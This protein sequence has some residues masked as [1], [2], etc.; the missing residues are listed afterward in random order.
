[1]T[2]QAGIIGTGGVAGMG[3]LGMHDQ[4][5]IGKEPVDAS[6]AG[7]YARSDEIDLVAAAD[8]DS[9]KLETFGEVWEIAPDRRYDDHDAMLAAEDL[10]VVSVATP[11][12]LHH[13]HVV[14][15]AESGADP[16]VIWCEK[17]IASSVADAEAMVTAC[18][19]AGTELV[20]NHTT[21]FTENMHAVRTLVRD[22]LIG[23]IQAGSGTFRMELMRNSTHLIDTLVYLLDARA[24]RVSGYLTGENEAVDAL[25]ADTSVDDQGGGGFVI[26]DDGTFVTIDCT[27]P[28]EYSTYQYD[29]VGSDGKLR[30]NV[31]D[32]EWRYWDLQEG[33]HVEEELGDVT[34]DPDEWAD[35]F[36]GAVD[37][38]VELIEGTAENR[39]P[40]SAAIRSLEVIVAFYISEYTGSHVEIPLERPLKDVTITSW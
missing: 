31:N 28:R 5:L 13:D 7:G 24:S 22:G 8:I 15:A 23:D 29:L 25:E 38:L 19:D 32:G 26:L 16:E 11:T 17:P 18:A 1:M 12:F 34:H 27:V 6:H 20:V 14:D 21:R 4:E 10:D 40:G 3:L 36:A 37:H 30:I 33:T 39:S 9:E 2:Y 35:G